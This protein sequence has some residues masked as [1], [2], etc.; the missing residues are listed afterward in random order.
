[1]SELP[2]GWEQVNL[3]DIAHIESGIGF[4]LNY[5]GEKAGDLGFFKVGDIS[6]A[7]AQFGGQLKNAQHYVSYSVA[8]ELKGK[9]VLAGATV[10]AKI[11]EAIRLHRR[12]YVVE[13]CL[14][15][16]NVMA[17]KAFDSRSDRFLF[18]FMQTKDI[19]E[20]ARSTTVPSLRKGD[21]EGL[22]VPLAPLNEQKRIADKL[23][24]VLA[25][26]DAC[27]DRLDRIP[28]ILK[29]FRQ[30]VL[31]AATSGKLTE[32]WRELNRQPVG[33]A[34]DEVLQRLIL[35]R[36][37][38]PSNKKFKEPSACD[39]THWRLDIPST[40]SV[41]SVSAYAECLDHLRIPVTRDKRAN[42][43]GLYP[44]YGANG[45]VDMVDEYLFDDELVL[46]TED[47]T[48]Y[49]REKPIAYRTSGRC[50]VNNHAHVLLAGD[51]SRADYLC[52]A[53]M[54][55][56]VL[57]WL[58]GT[59]GRAK[60]TQGVLNSLPIAVPPET[61]LLE[62]VR[63][64]EALFAF[65]VRLEARYAAARA[66]VEKLTPATLAKAFRGELVSQDPNDEPASV[67]LE[68]IKAQVSNNQ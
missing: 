19:S 25:R 2:S 34:R 62:I 9:P 12:A 45:Q 11:G 18:R 40:W 7:V 3:S 13:D 26:V 24:A 66:Q 43:H 53:L 17:V 59:T 57:P 1:M 41:E 49:G 5:Q 37:K 23:D 20:L 4:P 42:T 33:K 28:A 15:D 63:R 6:R 68:H 56:D 46:V 50:W 60:L 30:S 31:A 36:E 27:R 35:R 47:E 58:T 67:L 8:S 44:Y 61:E 10:F 14:I 65:A 32:E 54:Y 29:R 64:V 38:N 51:R 52:Y 22:H 48:F 39:L 55:Y 21:I 16:N